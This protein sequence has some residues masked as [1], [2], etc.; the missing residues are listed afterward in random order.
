MGLSAKIEIEARGRTF[1]TGLLLDIVAALRVATQA[2]RGAAG[3]QTT[4]TT[5]CVW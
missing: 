2:T 3:D 4:F 1:A 5:S